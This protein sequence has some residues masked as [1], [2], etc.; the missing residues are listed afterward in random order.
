VDL[1]R[2][3][4]R[5]SARLPWVDGLAGIAGATMPDPTPPLTDAGIAEVE[6]RLG[7]DL[8][9]GLRHVYQTVAN[10]GFGPG[11]GL[12]GIGVDG[13]T[14]DLG[15]TADTRYLADRAP[16]PDWPLWEWPD[17]LLPICD[18]GCAIYHCVDCATGEILVWEPN[19]W[20]PEDA[21]D[22]AIFVTGV[23]ILDWFDRW[24]RGETLDQYLADPELTQDIVR[25]AARP[26]LSLAQ[27]RGKA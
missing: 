3:T 7:F 13:F 22:T 6:A 26:P 18:F 24:S 23:D 25:G 21:P 16:N 1:A 15:D 11:Y 10:G 27:R 4:D 14:D 17:K 8:P 2:L 9:S 19:L 5:L 12:T 20:T